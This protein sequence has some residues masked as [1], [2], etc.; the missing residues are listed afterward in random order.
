MS[1]TNKILVTGVKSVLGKYIYENTSNSVGLTREN[2]ANVYRYTRTGRWQVG[3][4]ELTTREYRNK[5]ASAEKRAIE[6]LDH[7]AAEL[8]FSRQELGELISENAENACCR[9]GENPSGDSGLCSDCAEEFDR[10]LAKD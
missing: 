6:I 10:D 9:C 1:S 3:T 5:R 4:P 2:R 8:E 7:L